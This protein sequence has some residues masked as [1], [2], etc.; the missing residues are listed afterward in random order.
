MTSS[1]TYGFN[2]RHRSLC[3]AQSASRAIG[4]NS[5]ARNTMTYKPIHDHE[6]LS[7]VADWILERGEVLAMIRYPWRGGATLFEFFDSLE[8]FRACI[9]GLGPSTVVIVFRERQLPLRGIIDA[10]FCAKAMAMIPEGSEYLMAAL[11]LTVIGRASWK[12]NRSGDNHQDLQS[13]LDDY[14]GG[15]VAFGPY[16][17]WL[18]DSDTV[19]SAIVPNADGTIVVGA[20]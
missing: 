8:A 5:R 20:Y 18:V 15:R 3:L 12:D 7:T 2:C 16:P 14:S 6:F 11:E 13:L 17:P 1:T 10:E 19:A 4:C 9:A